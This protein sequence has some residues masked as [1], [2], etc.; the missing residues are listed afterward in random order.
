MGERK[1]YKL[2][3]IADIIAG[4]AFKS[5]E[6]GRVGVSVVKI[7]DINPP[8][9]DICNTDKVDISVYPKE[10]MDKYKIENGDYVI[11]MTGATIGKVGRVR[12][13]QTAYI[14]QRVA[15]I[16]AKQGVDNDFV[17][18]AISG[19]DF[20]QFIQNNIDS[21]S[22]Q[23]NISATSIGKFPISLP[24]MDEQ[25]RIAGILSALD[26]KIE[27]NRRIN[28]NLELQAQ[29]LFNHWFVDFEFPN[30]DGKP[31]KSSGGKLID[32]PIGQIP[33]GWRIGSVNDIV[34]IQSGFAFKSEDFVDAGKYR[35][36]T[37]KN[38]QDGNMDIAGAVYIDDVPYKMPSYCILQ[39][40]DILLSLTGNVGRCCIVDR[41]D[42]LL[43][44]RVAKLHPINKADILFTYAMFRNET[45]KNKMISIARG[46]AQ[47]NL[48]P[49][50]TGQ[51]QIIIPDDVTL[52]RFGKYG[53]PIYQSL[54]NNRQENIRLAQ[55][56]D[57][58]LPKLMNKIYY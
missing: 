25:K 13:E 45:F 6:F 43:N 8:Y 17:Y 40:G 21:N 33:E 54:L 19:N 16:K 55:L 38:V 53:T 28:A 37:I 42:L 46:T 57:T 29:T 1:K 11:A 48:S 14:N 26:D 31:Y 12:G 32:S 44:Q 3:D 39:C 9:V 4:Y 47:M 35:L 50:E 30:A 10:K 52:K 18:Y 41:Q 36:V 24:P 20:Q 49:I 58:L 15:K 7:K 56:R 34:D 5:K 51:L 22:A 27:L 23:E 2:S